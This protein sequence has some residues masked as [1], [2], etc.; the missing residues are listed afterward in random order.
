MSTDPEM[1]PDFAPISA[2]V[3]SIDV[4]HD[5]GEPRENEHPQ[6]VMAV[7]GLVLAGLIMVLSIAAFVVG[8]ENTVVGI[9]PGTAAAEFSLRDASDRRV[10]LGE[11]LS[12]RPVL[13]LFC[14]DNAVGIEPE[15]LVESMATASDIQ[16]V[17][18]RQGS[19][20]CDTLSDLATSL[21]QS[22]IDLDDSQLA[23]AERYGVE[24]SATQP[25]MA[26][27]VDQHGKILSRGS[28]KRVL[29]D[30]S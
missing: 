26:V 29:A 24:L 21:G 12:D 8:Q 20:T 10:T 27:L 30:V 11:L 13:L 16:L 23:V 15:Q 22:I 19:G 14:Q 18:V 28:V 9:E 3:S 7:G 1:S 5:A 17:A 6:R 4:E 25:A 2:E